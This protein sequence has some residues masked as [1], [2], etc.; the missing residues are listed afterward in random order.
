MQKSRT[1]AIT[2]RYAG[3]AMRSRLEARWAVFFDH[4]GVKWEYEPE[5]FE[6]GNGLRYLPDFWLPDWKMWVEVKPSAIDAVTRE[7]ARRLVAQTGQPIYCTEGMP[8]RNGVIFYSRDGG[9]TV[10]ESP[11]YAYFGVKDWRVVLGFGWVS[12]D[13]KQDGFSLHSAPYSAESAERGVTPRPG[14]FQDALFAARG[15]RFEFGEKGAV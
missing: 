1:R 6:L 7:K 10:L 12:P 11:A 5:G 4:L 3:Y 9:D 15:S 14:P 2:T 8:D 13:H